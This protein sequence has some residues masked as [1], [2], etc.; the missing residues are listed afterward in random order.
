MLNSYASGIQRNLAHLKG[1]T[2]TNPFLHALIKFNF[3]YF[4]LD[5]AMAEQSWHVDVHQI[6]IIATANEEGEPTPE[7][8]HHDENDFICMHLANRQNI[9]G[10]ATTITVCLWQVAGYT[11][12]WIR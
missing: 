2:L 7:G 10:G 12:R 11:I 4:P 1:S 3:R 5:S 8:I 6:R 9:V